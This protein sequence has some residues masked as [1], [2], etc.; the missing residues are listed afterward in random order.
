MV[1][2]KEVKNTSFKLDLSKMSLMNS[3]LSALVKKNVNFF[4]SPG[5]TA[6]IFLAD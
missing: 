2:L 6:T 3:T 4:E 5:I 1:S